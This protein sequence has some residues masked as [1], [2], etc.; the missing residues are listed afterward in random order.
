MSDILDIVEH[1]N[2]LYK[3]MQN[4]ELSKGFK[5]GFKFAHTFNDGYTIHSFKEDAMIVSL[6]YNNKEVGIMLPKFKEISFA[7]NLIIDV[8]FIQGV[9][10]KDKSFKYPKEW[11]S[12]LLYPLIAAAHIISPNIYIV[13]DSCNKANINHL[14]SQIQSIK[15][16]LERLDFD[17]KRKAMDKS[18]Y[19]NL[20]KRLNNNLKKYNQAM[21]FFGTIRDRY[22]NK[23]GYLNTNKIRVKKAIE[24]AKKIREKIFKP[25]LKVIKSPKVKPKNYK[26]HRVL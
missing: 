23:N 11:Y 6:S 17:Y 21:S 9:K 10:N 20:S 22:F 26:R 15:R 19:E 24:V 1:N 25:K 3:L 16:D 13:Y 5:I 12:Q 8:N 2:R 18:Q 7:N 14:K 4:I